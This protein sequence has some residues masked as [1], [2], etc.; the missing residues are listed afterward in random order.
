MHEAMYGRGPVGPR[1]MRMRSDDVAGDYDL[2][3]TCQYAVQST[4]KLGS[5]AEDSVEATAIMNQMVD[6]MKRGHLAHD[7]KDGHVL[8][9]ARLYDISDLEKV[10]RIDYHPKTNEIVAYAVEYDVKMKVVLDVDEPGASV[11]REAFR[12]ALASYNDWL[13]GQ[14]MMSAIEID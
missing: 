10:K 13:R 11:A 9:I 7:E 6:L 3:R 8:T 12:E 5:L 4:M 1:G 14:S 2:A